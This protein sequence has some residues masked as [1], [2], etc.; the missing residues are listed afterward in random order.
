MKAD[1]DVIS[2]KL[3][4]E[5]ISRAGETDVKVRVMV[6]IPTRI[7]DKMDRNRINQGGTIRVKIIDHVT[8]Y[9]QVA[10]NNELD[11]SNSF[12]IA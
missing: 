10:I 11:N 6:P 9:Y 8:Q 3:P 12:E 7:A 4:P 1:P 5:G 2:S